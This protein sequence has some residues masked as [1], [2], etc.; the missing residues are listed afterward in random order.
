MMICQNCVYEKSLLSS[1]PV[2]AWQLGVCDY[3][4]EVE[5]MVADDT[6][7]RHADSA[8]WQS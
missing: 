8:F 5:V 1:D 3:C 7:F 4:K 2:V 6:E